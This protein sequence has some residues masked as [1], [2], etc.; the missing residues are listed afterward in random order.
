MTTKQGG[1]ANWWVKQPEL[2]QRGVMGAGALIGSL[3]VNE[4]YKAI[5]GA[6]QKSRGFQQM[7]DNN[8]AIAKMDRGKVQQMYNTLHHLSP[9]M[10]TDP[11]IAGSFIKR[12]DGLAD[13]LDPKTLTD[14]ASVEERA[15]KSRPDFG[16]LSRDVFM[17][18]AP[19]QNM[20]GKPEP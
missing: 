6:I 16:Q 1:I 20:F 9:T 10:A 2:I 12:M 19:S 13:Y 11:L 7:V 14:I 8:P 3:A 4:G 15:R 18:H 17:G 5:S